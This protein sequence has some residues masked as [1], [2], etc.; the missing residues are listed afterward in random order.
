MA[1]WRTGLFSSCYQETELKM[2]SPNKNKTNGEKLPAS[3]PPCHLL[4]LYAATPGPLSRVRPVPST[5]RRA[6]CHVLRWRWGWDLGQEKRGYKPVACPKGMCLSSPGGRPGG[7]E[8]QVR[9]VQGREGSVQLSLS[10]SH[11]G[12]Q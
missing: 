2:V 12:L 11:K 1:F 4:G 3:S 10:L 6:G 8:G 9:N 5:R 7:R